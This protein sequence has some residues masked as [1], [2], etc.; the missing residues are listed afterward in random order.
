MQSPPTEVF[1]AKAHVLFDD[2][3]LTESLSALEKA[4]VDAED[5]PDSYW[6]ARYLA[7]RIRSDAGQWKRATNGDDILPPRRFRFFSAYA[8]RR[9]MALKRTGQDERF[10]A[11]CKSVF[12][13]RTV[14]ADPFTDALYTELLHTMAEQTFGDETTELLEEF[15]TRGKT[16]DR[17]LA[18]AHV[19]IDRGRP[20]NAKAAGTWLIAN[21]SNATFH[22]QYYAVRAIAS[23][24]KTT[25]RLS[26]R[27]YEN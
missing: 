5:S 3:R 9:A 16:Y 18:Y 2:G 17:V 23:F 24:S 12:R 15:G 27:K 26:K 14:A 8:Y 4:I 10:L 25:P 19:A 1:L 21:H 7:L 13:D 11:I 6:P 22:A 20:A